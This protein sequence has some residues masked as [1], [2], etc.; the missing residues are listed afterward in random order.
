MEWE[1]YI[2]WMEEE[3]S[4]GGWKRHPRAGKWRTLWILREGSTEKRVASGQ[5]CHTLQKGHMRPQERLSFYVPRTSDWDMQDPPRSGSNLLF[6][7]DKFPDCLFFSFHFCQV[8]LFCFLCVSI[9]F[10]LLLLFLTGRNA[11]KFTSNAAFHFGWSGID[12]SLLPAVTALYLY[13]SVSSHL[14]PDVIVTHVIVFFLLSCKAQKSC[15]QNT[16]GFNY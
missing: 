11:V 12:L 6:Q 2:E 3:K 14:L 1:A 7:K 15:L 13:I 10:R 4:K 16:Q 9:I 5:Q 8:E